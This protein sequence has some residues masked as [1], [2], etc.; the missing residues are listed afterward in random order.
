M[1]AATVDIEDPA[2]DQFLIQGAV[3]EFQS[4]QLATNIMQLTGIFKGI[5]SFQINELIYIY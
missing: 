1:I 4:H 2:F 5:E 3:A